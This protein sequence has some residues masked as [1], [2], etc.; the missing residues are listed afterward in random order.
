MLN[1]SWWSNLKAMIIEKVSILRKYN[2]N[3]TSEIIKAK[4]S[5][6]SQ[7]TL[8]RDVTEMSTGIRN[9]LFVDLN[10]WHGNV[11]I[12]SWTQ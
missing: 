5:L 7:K 2:L 1:L 9:K 12:V 4:I 10:H 6:M 3:I 11:L 8:Y